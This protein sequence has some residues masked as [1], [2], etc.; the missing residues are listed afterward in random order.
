M[1]R[2]L[3]PVEILEGKTV[4]TG[5]MDLL[6]TM[7]VTVLGYH[8]LPE[9]TPPDQARMQY[10]ERATAALA[11][12]VDSFQ[13]AGGDA[14]HRLVFTHNREQTID[15]IADET[16]ADAVAISGVTAAID[17]LLVTISGDVDVDRIVRFAVTLVGDR[18]ISL[19]LLIAGVD[20]ETGAPV[21]DRAREQLTDAGIDVGVV[22][23]PD[24]TPFNALMDNIPGHDAVVMGERAPSVRSLLFGDDAERVASA[25]VGPVIVVRRQSDDKSV[26]ESGDEPGRESAEEPDN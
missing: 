21:L 12:L 23:E 7:D 6:A 14:D 24:L 8:E 22:N 11:D 3:V 26:A 25:T 13:H 15:R 1:T 5:L 9:Q 10:E 17:E 4:D 2:V 16:A 19:T 18:D 20:E